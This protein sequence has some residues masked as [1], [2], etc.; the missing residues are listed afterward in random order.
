MADLHTKFSVARPPRDPT[1][2][3]SHTFSLNSA[4]S[5]V[6]APSKTGPRP[7]REI[8]DPPLTK[9][10]KK[11]QKLQIQLILV[12]LTIADLHFDANFHEAIKMIIVEF[13]S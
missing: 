7:L 8:L 4:G 9:N 11:T 2:A 13:W 6:H 5:E 10:Q 1:L 12:N 3:F